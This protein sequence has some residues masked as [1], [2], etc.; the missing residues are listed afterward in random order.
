MLEKITYLVNLMGNKHPALL[1]IVI[2]DNG[3]EVNGVIFWGNSQ[4]VLTNE[5][6]LPGVLGGWWLYISR[7]KSIL[8]VTVRLCLKIS[9][10]SILEENLWPGQENT[11]QKYFSILSVGWIIPL[12]PVEIKWW[13]SNSQP[14]M[15]PG[16]K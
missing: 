2:Q 13:V 6:F 8:T 12:S 4:N 5:Q 10:S 15:L 9:S 7:R 14:G 3:Q 11:L 1:F 16:A